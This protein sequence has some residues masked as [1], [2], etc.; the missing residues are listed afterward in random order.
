MNFLA[1]LYLS[2]CEEMLLVG[3][4]IADFISNK[5]LDDIPNPIREGIMLHR[6]IDSYTDQHPEVLRGVRRLYADHG[7]YAMVII[8]IFY[9][10]LLANNWEKYSKRTL[11]D[12]ARDTYEVLEQFISVMPP[13]LQKRL[14]LMIADDWLT[15]YASLEGI[16]FTI[17]RMK[18]RASRPELFDNSVK[19]LQR[20]YEL[21]NEEF[22]AFF[23]DVQ[24]LVKR[25]I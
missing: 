19:S 13:A 21:L 22:N 16:A 17:D 20:D 4:F 24:Q 25:E 23:P 18:R 14:P 11:P 5:Q 8:D 12:F 2:R 7:K 1:H 3:N 10:Y 15:N 6:K 9:D